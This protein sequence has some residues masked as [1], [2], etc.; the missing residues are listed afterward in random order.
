M[1]SPTPELPPVALTIAG[2]DSG[3]GA[4]IQADLVTMAASGVYGTSVVTAVTAQHTRGVERSFALPAR[5]VEAQLSAV[6]DDFEIGAA[7]TGMLATPEIVETVAERAADFAFPLVVD[8][9]MVATSGDRLLEPAAEAAYEELVGTAALVTPNTDEAA[10]L[11][12][13]DVADETSARE[14]GGALLERGADAAL[15]TGG[16]LSGE[17][18]RDVLV[19]PGGSRTFEHPRVETVAT[20]GSGCTLSAAI[21]AR[22][23]AGEDLEAAVSA[24]TETVAR[25]VRRYYDVGRGPGAV[26]HAV[27]LRPDAPRS[28][29]AGAPNRDG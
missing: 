17:R 6:A 22:L 13:I 27:D 19:T 12:G 23:A 21:T 4:G 3:G 25:A 5:E 2:S 28:S 26:N 16:H 15:V 7:K 20:H 18:V 24:A 9:V 10:V 8:P 11:T 29:P 1:R 14:A